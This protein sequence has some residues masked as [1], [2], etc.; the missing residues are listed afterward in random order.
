MGQKI[1]FVAQE[2]T[3]GAAE[4]LLANVNSVYSTGR[5]TE[6]NFTRTDSWPEEIGAFSLVGKITEIKGKELRI[7]ISEKE[8]LVRSPRSLNGTGLEVGDEVSVE[9]FVAPGDP[10][11]IFMSD[12]KSLKVTQT[13]SPEPS[14]REIDSSARLPWP[15]AMALAAAVAGTGLLAY[16]RQERIKRVALT[17]EPIEEE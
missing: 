17:Q 2:K 4:F 12:P 1:G 15:I 9:G 6:I 7:R 10:P 5:A 14:S 11:T 8:G 3:E 16:L 13:A